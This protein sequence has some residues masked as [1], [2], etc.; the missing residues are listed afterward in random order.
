MSKMPYYAPYF[1][2]TFALS[3]VLVIGIKQHENNTKKPEKKNVPAIGIIA[4]VLGI[5][6]FLTFFFCIPVNGFNITDNWFKQEFLCIS[7]DLV[8]G[9]IA[10]LIYRLEPPAFLVK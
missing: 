9:A 2:V 1:I 10:Y 5:L 8:G 4:G 3:L 7:A 6:V